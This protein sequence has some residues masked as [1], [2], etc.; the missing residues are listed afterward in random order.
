MKKLLLLLGMIV[1]SIAPVISFATPALAVDIQGEFQKSLKT[2]GL[3]KD[4]VPG[5]PEVLDQIIFSILS[6]LGVVILVI[7]IYAGFQW[8]TAAGNDT[9][10]Q[11]AQKTLL[12]AVIGLIIVFASFAI[13]SFV[14]DALSAA[15]N[16]S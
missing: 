2:S 3:V 13:T 6:L 1:T 16:A 7:I 10:V 14:L 9:K 12:Q 4:K 11:K 8:A 15:T 5:V